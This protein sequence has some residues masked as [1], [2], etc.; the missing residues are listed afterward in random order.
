MAQ[1]AGIGH[2]P[3]APVM[4]D[5]HWLVEAQC[6]DEVQEIAAQC[7]ELAAAWGQRVAKA[8]LAEA[9]QR[10]AEHPV[11]RCGQ[12]LGHGLPA[13]GAIRPAVHEHGHLLAAGVPFEISDIQHGCADRGVTTHAGVSSRA[14]V[15][16][17]KPGFRHKRTGRSHRTGPFVL[18]RL[19]PLEAQERLAACAAS[20]SSAPISPS[21]F[22]HT[23]CIASRHLARCS[24]DNS[25]ISVLPEATMAWR[26]C[27][28]R[29]S[30]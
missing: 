11:A 19:V 26:A 21:N 13:F 24:G 18:H 17:H 14:L 10:R 3:R 6:V 16:Q 4:A 7:G 22:F 9:A 25:M 8:C 5:Q 2:R 27:W 15:G 29:S 20:I 30:A 1:P 28:L 12:A 23:G